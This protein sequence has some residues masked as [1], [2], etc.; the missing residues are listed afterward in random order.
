LICCP[1]RGAADARIGRSSCGCKC[2][3]SQPVP[4]CLQGVRV[5]PA[6]NLQG[7]KGNSEQGGK[8]GDATLDGAQSRREKQ[9][10]PLVY[11]GRKHTMVVQYF[12]FLALSWHDAL[13]PRNDGS[14]ISTPSTP[15]R[16]TTSGND[17]PQRF[18]ST[19]PCRKNEPKKVS[20]C[21]SK[22]VP[23]LAFALGGEGRVARPGPGNVRT[24]GEILCTDRVGPPHT[25]R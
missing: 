3:S 21:V 4:A 9:G 1:D 22:G 18:R 14:A 20:S 2:G 19:T 11:Q 23:P 16:E 8:N 6:E 7:T 24:E 13:N 5:P 17:K 15:S 25:A 12:L 10:A